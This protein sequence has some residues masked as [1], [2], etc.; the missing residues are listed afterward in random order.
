MKRRLGTA[1]VIATAIMGA[2]CAPV[3][4][5]QTPTPPTQSAAQA[6]KL[7]IRYLDL[8]ARNDGWVTAQALGVSGSS[9]RKLVIVSYMDPTT[10]RAFYDIAV[11]FTRA[12]NKLPIFGV[13]RAPQ[14]PTEPHV[15]GFDI[16]ING[17]PLGEIKDEILQRAYSKPELLRGLLELIQKDDYP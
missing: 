6:Q 12:P 9:E 11:S 14:H 15:I 10:T 17:L 3:A 4:L 2:L 13:V 1:R 16:Y 8:T 5:A 7:P